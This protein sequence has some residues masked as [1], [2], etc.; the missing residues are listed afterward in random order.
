MHFTYT[1]F[2]MNKKAIGGTPESTGETSGKR[3][4]LGR[5]EAKQNQAARSSVEVTRTLASQ[6]AI[7][8][9]NELIG[10]I[11]SIE[12]IAA[13][14]QVTTRAVQ[15]YLKAGKRRGVKVAGA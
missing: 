8:E 11:Y 13:A 9:I 4:R 6:S 7:G 14:L 10:R 5:G 2:L 1:V 3:G 12:E 15:G